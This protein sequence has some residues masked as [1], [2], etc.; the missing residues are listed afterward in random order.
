MQLNVS[1]GYI[2][3]FGSLLAECQ[4]SYFTTGIKITMTINKKLRLLNASL[5]SAGHII[6]A[7]FRRINIPPKVLKPLKGP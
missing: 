3:H 7:A 1:T 2:E 6:D 5:H 4:E